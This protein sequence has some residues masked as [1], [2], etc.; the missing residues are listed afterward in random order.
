VFDPAESRRDDKPYFR[1]IQEELANGGREA[2]LYDLLRRPLGDFHPRVGYKTVALQDQKRHSL[3]PAF[4]ALEAMLQDGVLAPG[5]VPPNAASLAALVHHSG[6]MVPFL[7]TRSDAELR[8]A[9]RLVGA[10]SRRNNTGM[11]RLWYFPPLAACRGAWEGKFGPW[12]WEPADD[13]QTEARSMK[14]ILR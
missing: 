13:W 3:E 9:M 1:A 7:K 14:D 2:M 11:S 10:V 8:D 6:E 4:K 5:A 12:K